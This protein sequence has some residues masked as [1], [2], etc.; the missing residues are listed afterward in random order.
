MTK[1]LEAMKEARRQARLALRSARYAVGQLEGLTEVL[2]P[3]RC[4]CIVADAMIALEDG[5][6]DAKAAEVE[7]HRASN[8]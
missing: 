1:R 7:F 6:I 2:S 8:L 3:A 4:V 5:A